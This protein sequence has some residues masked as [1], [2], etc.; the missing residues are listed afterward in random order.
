MKPFPTNYVMKRLAVF[1]CSMGLMLATASAELKVA[2]V[3]MTHLLNNYY[4]SKA[5]EEE[6]KVNREAIKEGDI[7][8]GEDIKTILDELKKHQTDL[9]DPQLSETKRKSILAI[10]QEKNE[11]MKNL[12]AE[13]KEFLERSGRALNEKM[14]GLM[15]DIRADVIDAVNKYAEGAEV[16]YVFDESG[17]TSTQV[18][19]IIYVRNRVDITADVLKLLNKDAPA[20]EKKEGE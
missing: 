13:R 17:L 6:E 9:R 12:Q 15:N 1:L 8:R 3:D 7:K 18:P 19:F 10:A 2:M 14:V 16:D 20:A 5:A 11:S 4:K